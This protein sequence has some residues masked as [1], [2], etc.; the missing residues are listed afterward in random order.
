VEKALSQSDLPKNELDLL[1]YEDDEE[2]NQVLTAEQENALLSL[3][4]E[5]AGAQRNVDEAGQHEIL[6]GDPFMGVQSSTIQEDF[7]EALAEVR[8]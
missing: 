1:A 3:T 6:W 7:L 2:G 5:E 8:K 4:P